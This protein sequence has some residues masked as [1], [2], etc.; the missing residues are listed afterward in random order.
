MVDLVNIVMEAIRDLVPLDDGSHW[1]PTFT[2]RW[3]Q[4]YSQSEIRARR[5]I[6]TV[7]VAVITRQTRTPLNASRSP[8]EAPN[9]DRKAIKP[10]AGED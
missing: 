2:P 9:P 4:D 5:A 8:R 7:A 3:P 10:K 1:N 6:A